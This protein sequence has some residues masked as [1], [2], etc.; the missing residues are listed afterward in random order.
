M[1]DPNHATNIPGTRG[2][3]RVQDFTRAHDEDSRWGWA[4]TSA[5]RLVSNRGVLQNYPRIG[6][7]LGVA[8]AMLTYIAVTTAFLGIFFM[9]GESIMERISQNSDK[10]ETLTKTV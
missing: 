7:G 1:N 8:L 4:L 10:I 9:D 6:K 2:F 3:T 5:V